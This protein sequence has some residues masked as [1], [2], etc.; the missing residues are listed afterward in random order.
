MLFRSILDKNWQRLI[1]T[2]IE[3][4][5]HRGVLTGSALTDVKITIL[6]GRAHIKHT[7]GG[8][9]RKAT[10]RAIRNGLKRGECILL[11]P[12]YDFILEIPMEHVG[13]AL[14]DLE[15]RAAR[16]E[17]PEFYTSGSRDMARIT[18]L[19]PVSTMQDYVSEVMAYSQG[20]G[21]LTL[22]LSGYYE[23]HNP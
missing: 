23:C 12:Y 11:E 9:F 14:T 17:S 1:A 16:V 10:Y 20:L 13:R 8:D 21:N 18:G 2:H 5:E 4:R 3:E 6:S 19:A 15:Q 7:E 22:D